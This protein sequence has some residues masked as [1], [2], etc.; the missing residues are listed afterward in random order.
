MTSLNDIIENLKSKNL[1]IEDYNRLLIEE[2]NKLPI[3]SDEEFNRRVQLNNEWEI[4]VCDCFL[5][6]G[7]HIPEDSWCTDCLG[8][9]PRT[10]NRPRIPV[11]P[12][13]VVKSIIPIKSRSPKVSK[14]CINCNISIMSNYKGKNILCKKCLYLKKKDTYG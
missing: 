3:M 10:Y 8:I 12:I 5:Y 2:N 14:S 1:S 9:D 6:G 11:K 4:I 13:I 7:Y